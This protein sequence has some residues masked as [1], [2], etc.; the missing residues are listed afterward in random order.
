MRIVYLLL[1]AYVLGHGAVT[2]AS[3]SY[4]SPCELAYSPD[5]RFLA[6]TDRTSATL[7]ILDPISGKAK[8]R[9]VLDNPFMDVTWNTEGLWGTDYAAGCLVR[10]DV[11]QGC[12]VQ[13]IPTTPKP[14]GMAMDARTKTFLVCGYGRHEIAIMGL[15]RGSQSLESGRFPY[16]AD[17]TSDGRMGVVGNLLPTGASLDRDVAACVCL[18]DMSHQILLKE[19]PLPYGSANVRGVAIAPDDRWA[20]VVHTRGRVNLPT[21]Q[22]ERGWVN[23]NALTVID[24][25]EQQ[26]Y[27]TL[28]LDTVQRGG[29]DPWGVTVAPDGRTVW[30]TLA[31]VHEIARLD[32]G[33][34]QQYLKGQAFPRHL[35]PSD[36]KAH[37]AYDV[38]EGIRKDPQRR[39]DLED[40]LSAL[41][42]AGLLTRT[43][44]CC[45][46]PRGVT[47]S[48]N[49]RQ[50]AVAGY[51][52]GNVVILDAATLAVRHDIPLGEHTPLTPVRRGEM[53]FHDGRQC[54]Q[55]WLSCATCHPDGRADGL[56]WDLLN[57]GIGNPKN[58]KSLVLAHETPPAMSTGV[59]A[60]FEVAVE[61]GFRHILM[62]EPTED[63]LLA[64]QAYLRS[65]QPESSP[66]LQGGRLSP[67]ALQGKTLFQDPQVGCSACHSGPI[68]TDLK[69]RD[70]GTRGPF[71]R[72]NAFDNPSLA[73]LWRTAPY[74]H[75]GAAAT[76]E[77][78]LCEHNAKDQHGE[79][80]H[81]T[82]RKIEALVAYLLSL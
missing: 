33:L 57:D 66:F 71:D 38:W 29:A 52:S 81:L 24:L 73:E 7:H 5:G 47:G 30:V 54:F 59:R 53:L 17:I 40:E 63:E 15:D 76:L 1:I 22:L 65:L 25:K 49:G 20:F 42:A 70:V 13:R 58:T 74:L 43:K 10:V 18:I 75:H 4:H 8:Q 69:T 62:H 68:Y 48:P 11:E 80:S 37:L 77:S 3:A 32:F 55:H 60:T 34:L 35:K 2:Y 79:T 16:Y 12:I 19:I 82:Q 26:R 36:A 14:M 9:I 6:V 41:Y 51:F 21:S 56:N 72:V 45:Q 39:Y 27:V 64:V 46:G 61:A 23:T 78:L 50:L 44:L 31:G 28:L 67:L